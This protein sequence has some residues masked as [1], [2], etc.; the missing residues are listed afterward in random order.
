M[1]DNIDVFVRGIGEWIERCHLK[2]TAFISIV[3]IALMWLT[4]VL[5][6][7]NEGNKHGIASA[8]VYAFFLVPILGF[9]S[10]YAWGLFSLIGIIIFKILRLIFYNLNTLLIAILFLYLLLFQRPFLLNVWQGISHLCNVT[11]FN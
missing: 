8:L 2:I 5:N 11:I 1:R 3:L 10:F 9:V 4:L 7:I 6:L